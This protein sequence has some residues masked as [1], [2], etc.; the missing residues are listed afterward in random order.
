MAARRMKIGLY[1]ECQF[2]ITPHDRDRNLVSSRNEKRRINHIFGF[3]HLCLANLKENITS[4]DP[5]SKGWRV[6]HD[7]RHLSTRAFLEFLSC[8]DVDADP[9]MPRFAETNEIIP[10]LL[11]GIDGQGM[12]GRA[13]F[14]ASNE[15][16]DD[17]AL[18]IQD[19]RAG[20]SALGGH[21]DPQMGRGKITP[22]NFS[23]ETGDHS[24][25]GRSR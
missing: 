16:A 3:V 19:R 14:N 24:E 25:T 7:F 22:E 23:I 6:L 15:Y 8:S 1:L 13:V 9:A 20:L 10:D 5:R 18:E 21:V 4:L 2:F 17:L 11:R 12:A